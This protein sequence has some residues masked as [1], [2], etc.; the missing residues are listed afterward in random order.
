V[1]TPALVPSGANWSLPAAG[2][3]LHS[4]ISNNLFDPAYCTVD[5]SVKTAVCSPQLT[6]RRIML[7]R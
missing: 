2:A 1:L 7:N 3:T 4:T 5:E 6:F